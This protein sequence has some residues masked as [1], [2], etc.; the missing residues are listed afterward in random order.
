MKRVIDDIINLISPVK[1]FHRSSTCFLDLPNEILLMICRYMSTP[2]ILHCFYTPET[3]N[4]RL[5]CLISDYYT[6]INLD[7]ITFDKCNYLINLFDSSNYLL[8][9][10]SLKL[11]NEHVSCLITHY[12]SSI[13]QKII[14]AI[15]VNLKDLTLIDCLPDDLYTIDQHSKHLTKLQ[16]LHVTFR[17]FKQDFDISYVGKNDI[18]I[19]RLLFSGQMCTLHT[20]KIELNNGLSLYKC[21]IPHQSLRHVQIIL[22][23]IDDLYIL[24]NGL[25]PNVETMIVQLSQSRIL[26]CTRIVMDDMEYILGYMTNLRKLTLNIRD[27]PDSRFS[28]GL[29][30]ESILNK[31]VP[32][33][34]QFDYTMTHRI[35]D[36]TLIEDFIRWTMKYIYYEIDNTKWIHIYSLPWP[37]TRQDKREIPI[38]NGQH[39]V[40]VTSDV[41]YALYTNNVNIT[42]E[43]ELL[44][45]N[46]KFSQVHQLRTCLSIDIILPQRISKLILSVSSINSIPQPSIRHLI[47][48]RRL[49]DEKEINILA[50][51]FPRVNYLELLFPL[52]KDHFLRCFK[53]LFNFDSTTEKHFIWSEMICFHTVINYQ[54]RNSI[55]TNEKLHYWLIQNTDLKFHSM[56]FY[57]NCSN[58]MFSVWL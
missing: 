31:Y 3:P 26:S 39:D 4:M 54:Q 34:C 56:P 55:Y 42:R 53:T 27:T 11:S 40:S 19:N 58:S 51:Q 50:R 35:S 28:N 36:T 57:A 1:R 46:K 21:L 24:L 8:Q 20:I 22:R 6:K 23:T 43:N 9:P 5:H 2:D 29:T 37:S 48:E 12:F 38:V 33:L 15:F 17:K 44:E 30:M 41:K 52:E 47:I 10:E 32:H 7:A 25:I 18:I 14:E 45:I 16:Y 13:S 49:I